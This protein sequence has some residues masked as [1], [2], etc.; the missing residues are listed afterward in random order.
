MLELL[1]HDLKFFSNHELVIDVEN[2][3]D[4]LEVHPGYRN[5]HPDHAPSPAL[6]REKANVLRGL[7][8]AGEQVKTAEKNAARAELI[9]Y[10]AMPAVYLSMQSILKNDQSY[11]E[12]T[13]YA[14][15]GKR[16]KSPPTTTPPPPPTG[17]TVAQGKESGTLVLRG[18]R[19]LPNL[20][21]EVQICRG[22]PVGEA[23]WQ[24]LAMRASCKGIEA[25]GLEPGQKYFFRVRSH[26]TGGIGPWSPI[27]GRMV[28]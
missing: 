25:R 4:H 21:Y 23:S 14:L 6:L 9:L 3:A 17:L 16:F 12:N 26:G 24:P 28:I 22:E 2:I 1:V 13:G 15:K 27:V 18:H 19:A 20:N 7:L 10:V 11:L 5:A 8:N